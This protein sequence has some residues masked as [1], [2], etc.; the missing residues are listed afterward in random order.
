MQ[1]LPSILPERAG[2]RK[3]TSSKHEFLLSLR[4]WALTEARLKISGFSERA[5]LTGSGKVSV[6]C[7][8]SACADGLL[9]PDT[10]VSRL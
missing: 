3:T 2:H 8:D 6:E 10:L 7:L 1:E 9:Q 5:E 4:G